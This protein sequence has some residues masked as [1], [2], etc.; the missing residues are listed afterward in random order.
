MEFVIY[1]PD[2]THRSLGVRM[3]HWL[4]HRL[5]ELGEK[6]YLWRTTVKHPALRTPSISDARTLRG[7]VVAVY[8]EVVPGNPIGGDVIVRWMLNRPGRAN[9]DTTPTWETDDIKL[10]WSE[11]YADTPV[12]LLY[13][14]TLD[15]WYFHNISNPFDAKR[16]FKL[17]YSAKA[18]ASGE[19]VPKHGPN[20]ADYLIPPEMLGWMLRY[21]K[22]LYLC[23]ESSMT[24]EAQ[25]CGCEVEYVFSKYL[26]KP[27]PAWH[28]PTE[29]Q[30][31]A[32]IRRLI[33]ACH[34]KAPIRRAA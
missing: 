33:D 8:P 1:A 12:D 18:A 4:C 9:K 15:R 21:S 31:V 26:P 28:E 16:S 10:Y 29:A 32:M 22:R 27:P 24:S 5:C 6:A 3:L 25:T 11:G 19:L 7:P 13:L 14:P 17:V 34:A 20:L 2:Y 30:T 23:E